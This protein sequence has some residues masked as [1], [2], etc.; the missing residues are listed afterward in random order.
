MTTSRA[1]DGAQLVARLLA[2]APPSE[3]EAAALSEPWASLAQ[4]ISQAKG[5]ER[6]V[7]FEA[8]LS[9]M[10]SAQAADIRIQV[11]R[12]GRAILQG[13]P[14]HT[15]TWSEKTGGAMPDLPQEA[16]LTS[17]LERAGQEVGH[18]LNDYLTYATDVS[19]RTPRLFHEAIGLWIGSLA[20]AR[21][22][23]LRLR[24]GDIYPNLYILGVASTTLYA[25]STGLDIASRLIHECFP[26]LL[27]ANDFTP[28]AMLAD[29]AGREPT[30]LKT[31]DLTERD[32]ELWL[33]GR[34]FAAQR[35]IMLEEA[36]ALLAGLRR[37]YM[38]GMAELLLRLYDCP[39]LYRRNTRGTGFIVVRKAYLSIIGVT[40]P[41]RLQRA[42][43]KTAWYDGLFARFALL[44]PKAPPERPRNDYERPR[45]PYPPRLVED[46]SR[47]AHSLLPV[48]A[49]PAPVEAR[50]VDMTDE[51]K[52]AWWRYYVA[53]TYD[54][55]AGS[56]PPNRQLW[57]SYGRLP[58]Q[59]LKIALILA[60]LD[61]AS[62]RQQEPQ[63]T[64]TH[65]ATGQV[66]AETWRASAQRLLHTLSR[67][68]V[69][70]EHS[71]EDRILQMIQAAG[72]SGITARNIYRA[73]GL[74]RAEFDLAVA[75]LVRDGLVQEIEIKPARGPS[76]CGYV[77]VENLSR[78][79]TGLT[80]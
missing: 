7:A 31:S 28:E 5:H 63:L 10:P 43:I 17:G 26:H 61:W 73:L 21:R 58:T 6:L 37:D 19:E 65:Y 30:N 25:K 36:S 64:L 75:G 51:A 8:A 16:R 4:A 54:L 80:G 70:A 20:I 2:G 12:A 52:A 50:D 71:R 59:A 56:S 18:W 55:L 40:T 45:P 74:R 27:F 76:A 44:T 66:I 72:S 3:L 79:R 42:E 53:V 57:G 41:A 24:H 62:G 23:R 69:A 39:A 38:T 47:L 14:G 48:P 46:V 15:P 9:P 22:L 49:F 60:A 67:S 77:A 78:G 33:A 32:R 11:G 1:G 29:L 68:Q 13:Q 34:N 35:G